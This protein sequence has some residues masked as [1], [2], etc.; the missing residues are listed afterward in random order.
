[1]RLSKYGG[2]KIC[3]VHYTEQPPPRQKMERKE[4]CASIWT[5]EILPRSGGEREG[6]GAAST[7]FFFVRERKNPFC[8]SLR[9]FTVRGIFERREGELHQLLGGKPNDE[10]EQGLGGRVSVPGFCSLLHTAATGRVQENKKHLLYTS[11]ADAAKSCVAG[12]SRSDVVLLGEKSIER[13][14][15]L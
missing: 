10:N 3:R 7:I 4:T 14:R 11:S 5:T 1:M 9:C 8:Q 12:F 6:G 13:V 15:M 2:S